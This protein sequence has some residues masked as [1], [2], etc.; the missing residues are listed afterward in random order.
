M[1]IWEIGCYSQL[2]SLV[3]WWFAG[4]SVFNCQFWTKIFRNSFLLQCLL[5]HP[6]HVTLSHLWPFC[7]C[8]PH[9]E[10]LFSTVGETM[11][12]K[13]NQPIFIVQ[14]ISTMYNHGQSTDNVLFLSPSNGHRAESGSFSPKLCV[15][16][17]ISALGTVTCHDIRR[18][19]HG[20]IIT[21]GI[22]DSKR[23]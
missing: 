17:K 22:R 7:S 9:N 18:A 20:L 11:W 19:G 14:F 23:G 4:D 10:D 8:V 3:Y 15:K 12:Y 1:V 21:T 5:W 6:L 16:Y 2:A 13:L